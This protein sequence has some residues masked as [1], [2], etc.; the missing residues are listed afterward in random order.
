[1]RLPSVHAIGAEAQVQGVV[2]VCEDFLRR[3]GAGL[4][5]HGDSR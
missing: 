5:R 4:C 2:A 3:Q 1:M